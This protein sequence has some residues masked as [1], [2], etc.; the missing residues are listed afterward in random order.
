[1]YHLIYQQELSKREQ[2]L[3]MEHS[4]LLRHH[5]STKDL[6]YRHLQNIQR[7]R[8][9]HLKKQHVTERDNQKEYN[10][11]EEANLRKKHLLEHKQQPRSLKVS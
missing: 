10:S 2:Q 6:E 9:E 11:R 8:D 3:Q 5:D 7:I 4:I 1:M